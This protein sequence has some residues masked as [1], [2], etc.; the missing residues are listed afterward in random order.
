VDSPH[1]LRIL[2]RSGKGSW[3]QISTI[4]RFQDV[5]AGASSV[6]QAW[7]LQASPACTL[8]PAQAHLSGRCPHRRSASSRRQWKTIRTPWIT[9]LAGGL[10]VAAHVA[11]PEPAEPPVARSS[12]RTPLQHAS[13]LPGC[14]CPA[15]AA[16]GAQSAPRSACLQAQAREPSRQDGLECACMVKG[17]QAAALA[18]G[19]CCS[20]TKLP[21]ACRI[22]AALLSAFVA[23]SAKHACSYA[24]G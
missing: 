7:S 21:W 6:P 14:G 11:L 17:G 24:L 19:T 1:S 4:K 3:K 9:D 2:C 22:M 20:T 16:C 10:P 13:N 23:A 8:H 12:S 18:H 5:Q 15:G